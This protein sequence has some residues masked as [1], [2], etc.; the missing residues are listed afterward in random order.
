MRFP[1]QRTGSRSVAS[2]KRTE[3]G[4]E[5]AAVMK[6]FR[7]AFLG[8]GAFSFISNLLMLT[9]PIFMLEIYDRVLPSH[10]LPT[11]A[12]LALFAIALYPAQGIIDWIRGRLL[13]RIAGTLDGAISGRAYDLLRDL[14]AGGLNRRE[15]I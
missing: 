13:V 8:L 9:G 7:S 15:E 6:S 1:W 2:E 4:G 14:C 11:L 10:S 3:G 5:L 12:L